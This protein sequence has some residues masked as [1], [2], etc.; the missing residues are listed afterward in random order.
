M[1]GYRKPHRFKK[2]RPIF[3][4]RFF[5][6]GVLTVT[7]IGF[8]IYF[9]FFSETF[10]IERVIISGEERAPRDNLE[11][12]VENRLNNKVLFFNTKSIFSINLGEIKTNIL[13]NFPQIVDVRIKQEFPDSLNIFV[14]ERVEVADWC[15]E[16]QCFLLDEEGIIFGDFSTEKDLIKIIDRR[17]MGSFIFGEK[18]MA[19]AL[20]HVPIMPV[21]DLH[22]HSHVREPGLTATCASRR[23]RTAKSCELSGPGIRAQTRWRAV[24]RS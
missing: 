16:E 23:R 1:R 9:L 19:N 10:Q 7:L 3:H 22:G 15:Q 14:V 12:M 6:L 21:I 8:V 11:E 20:Y 4:N 24:S 17:D 13:D 5:W 18:V 2:N